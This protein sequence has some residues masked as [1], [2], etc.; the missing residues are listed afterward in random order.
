MMNQTP[1]QAPLNVPSRRVLLYFP[2]LHTEADL[3]QMG[4]PIR[5]L[6]LQRL[7]MTGVAQ[8]SNV[9]DGI[10]TRIETFF[11]DP[12]LP[13]EKVYLY[14]DGLPVCGRET[15][16]VN[17]MARSGSRNHKLLA[18]LMTQGAKLMGT[19]SAELLVQEYALAQKLLA[20]LNKPDSSTSPNPL[21]EESRNLLA[22]RDQFIARRI[23]QTLKTGTTGI[24]FI[25]MLHDIITELDEDIN[26]V[27]PLTTEI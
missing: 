27:H 14:Q 9:I 26:V 12:Q 24:L 17:D 7:G 4:E 5:R 21:G 10:W 3:G 20:S 15:D 13:Y 1:I 22:Q 6:A 16:I 11:K 18:D 2:V 23:N 25:G 19:E 8:K